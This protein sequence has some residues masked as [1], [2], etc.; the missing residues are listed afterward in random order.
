MIYKDSLLDAYMT[1]NGSNVQHFAM[2][3][4]QI[5]V[6]GT[7]SDILDPELKDL[8]EHVYKV[9]IVTH[10]LCFVFK[11]LTV[12]SRA[13]SFKPTQITDT[14][15]VI[16]HTYLMLLSVESFATMQQ[17]DAESGWLIN[18][19]KNYINKKE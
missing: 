2:L 12:W 10:S 4:T 3:V 7:P 6:L 15:L 18:P 9:S 5:L 16:L 8:C 19:N 17:S 1:L 11:L 14:V 13:H